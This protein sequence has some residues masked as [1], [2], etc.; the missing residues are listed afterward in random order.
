MVKNNLKE[1]LGE[2]RKE[3]RKEGAFSQYCA[4]CGEMMGSDDIN[5]FMEIMEK[6]R[7]TCTKKNRG[8]QRRDFIYKASGLPMAG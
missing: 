2:V 8:K 3:L 1:E 5:K 7:L 4:D 6:H